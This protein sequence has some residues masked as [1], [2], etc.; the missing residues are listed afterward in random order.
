M[1]TSLRPVVPAMR[2]VFAVGSVLVAAAGIQ[3]FVLTDHTDTSFAWTIAPG[4]S[5]AFLGAFY[6]TA[7]VLAG[8][9]ALERQ[10]DRARVGVFGV[11]LFV[12]LTLVS[13]LLHL[14]KFH[15]H[16][17]GV[18]PRGAAWLWMLIYAI[19]PPAVLAAIVLQLLVP[20]HARPRER[21]LP[22]AYRTLLFAEAVL[23]LAIGVVMFAA[24]S[25][26][27][28]WPWALTPLVARAIGSWLLGLGVVLA[29]AA[30]EGDWDRIRIAT[31]AFVALGVLQ[32]I[33]VV[34]YWNDF[35]GGTATVLYLAFLGIVVLTGGLGWVRAGTP[36]VN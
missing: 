27:G 35:R 28:W 24:P 2:L 26:V 4:A 10:W 13:T 7:L 17:P 23:V 25:S 34:R 36:A 32:L 12:T 3:L 19:E 31:S 30:W 16:D 18:I 9:S 8:R 1:E 33:A 15:F 5:A 22:V 20:G 11:W 21:L 6:F 14:D 29:T